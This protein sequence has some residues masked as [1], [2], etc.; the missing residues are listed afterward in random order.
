MFQLYHGTWNMRLYDCTLIYHVLC[1]MYTMYVLCIMYVHQ[2]TKNIHVYVQCNMYFTYHVYVQC[3]MYFTY[4][5]A[6]YK[7][8]GG[9]LFCYFRNKSPF[10]EGG[11][12]SRGTRSRATGWPWPPLASTWTNNKPA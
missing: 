7:E 4:H 2:C 10:F 12:R 3:N 11:G 5:G 9:L 8:V 1:S 6:C